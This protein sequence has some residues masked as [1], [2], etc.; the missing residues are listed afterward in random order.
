ML[1]SIGALIVFLASTAALVVIQ[2]AGYA[3]ALRARQSQENRNT[4]QDVGRSFT[5]V[6][7]TLLLTVPLLLASA[8]YGVLLH[9]F[10]NWK[11]YLIGSTVAL[12]AQLVSLEGPALIQYS[13]MVVTKFFFPVYNDVILP[14]LNVLRVLWNIAAC[15]VSSWF[16]VQTELY[17]GWISTIAQ[18]SIADFPL[19]VEIVANLLLEFAEEVIR[20]VE[21]GADAD[22]DSYPA[23][24]Q[25]ANFTL[26]V[27]NVTHCACSDIDLLAVLVTEIV[28]NSKAHGA[29]F[30]W[31]NVWLST[32]RTVVFFFV[33]ILIRNVDF[34]TCSDVADPH[35]RLLCQLKRG[36]KLDRIAA[37]LC[38]TTRD[39]TG[40]IDESLQTTVDLFW[41]P[42]LV[43]P[44]LTIDISSRN[45]EDVGLGNGQSNRVIDLSD[46]LGKLLGITIKVPPHQ[47]LYS[48]PICTMIY[49]TNMTVDL[50]LHVDMIFYDSLQSSYALHVPVAP[51]IQDTCR[52]LTRGLELFTDAILDT[53]DS[54]VSVGNPLVGT[55]NLLQM[56]TNVWRAGVR[57]VTSLIRLICD[58]LAFYV[59]LAQVYLFDQRLPG[60]A[61]V[62]TF[63]K[64]TGNYSDTD[65]E[66]L[67][68]INQ[69]LLDFQE[70]SSNLTNTISG[71]LADAFGFTFL[72]LNDLLAALFDGILYARSNDLSGFFESEIY[73]HLARAATHRKQAEVS[74]ANV[75][76]EFTLGPEIN[77]NVPMCSLVDP[78]TITSTSNIRTSVSSPTI[79]PL[80]CA[81]TIAQNVF[82]LF[83]TFLENTVLI[84]L[85][86]INQI[87]FSSSGQINSWFKVVLRSG[88]FLEELRLSARGLSSGIACSLSSPL[89]FG[90]ILTQ[91]TVSLF[92]CGGEENGNTLGEI[93]FD[94][95]FVALR[96][97]LESP[98]RAILVP[99]KL[100]LGLQCDFVG[101][102]LGFS[103]AE[104]AQVSP[105][106]K[107]SLNEALLEVYRITIGAWVDLYGFLL[108]IVR[109]VVLEVTP[110]P[111]G[112]GLLVV[113]TDIFGSG[114]S[115]PSLISTDWPTVTEILDPIVEFMG[116]VTEFTVDL[117]DRKRAPS[118][119][120]WN[121]WWSGLTTLILTVLSPVIEYS[122]AL[123]L[124]FADLTLAVNPL[125]PSSLV[126]FLDAFGSCFIATPF[127]GQEIVDYF[128]DD[129]VAGLGLDNIVSSLTNLSVDLNDFIDAF[130]FLRIAV[131]VGY[132]QINTVMVG[133]QSLFGIGSTFNPWTG[134]ALTLIPTSVGP[135]S[136]NPGLPIYRRKRDHWDPEHLPSFQDYQYHRYPWE[137]RLEDVFGDESDHNETLVSPNRT[138][139]LN[140]YRN[141]LL[142][143]V[144]FVSLRDLNWT[145]I[146]SG[147]NFQN[148]TQARAAQVCLGEHLLQ[149]QA[150]NLT[151]Q[152]SPEAVRQILRALTQNHTWDCVLDVATVTTIDQ[153]VYALFY[154][155]QWPSSYQMM[156]P[157]TL[158]NSWALLQT[159]VQQIGQ[160]LQYIFT[161]QYMLPSEHTG[162][163]L[164]FVHGIRVSWR[165]TLFYLSDSAALYMHEKTPEDIVAFVLHAR[166]HVH[167]LKRDVSQAWSKRHDRRALEQ[168]RYEALVLEREEQRSQRAAAMTAHPA[169]EEIRT[170]GDFIREKVLVPVFATNSETAEYQD[171]SEKR[172][173]P[174]QTDSFVGAYDEVPM[175]VLR[176]HPLHR[177]LQMSDLI[178]ERLLGSRRKR[179][180]ERTAT[181]NKSLRTVNR[182]FTGVYDVQHHQDL[183]D[184]DL[185]DEHQQREALFQAL[186]QR[187]PSWMPRFD[188]DR[189]DREQYDDRLR[190]YAEAHM[191]RAQHPPHEH[192]G[193]LHK[194]CLH[195]ADQGLVKR[196]SSCLNQTELDRP[197]LGLETIFG[198][199]LQVRCLLLTR[200]IVNI[201]DI[202]CDCVDR[203]ADG[204]TVEAS[205]AANKTENGTVIVDPEAGSR[206]R[207]LSSTF[208]RYLRF[209]YD[210]EPQTNNTAP[211]PNP[212]P[213]VTTRRIGVN[214]LDDAVEW[215]WMP[216]QWLFGTE[217]SAY[218]VGLE[219]FR[220]FTETDTDNPNGLVYYLNWF[221]L[222]DCAAQRSCE[223]SRDGL[224]LFW[225][226]LVVILGFLVLITFTTLF[227]LPFAS[228]CNLYVLVVILILGLTVG[229][230]WSPLC[231]SR[232]VVPLCLAD[233]LYCGL[234]VFGT[235]CINYDH[236]LPGITENRCPTTFNSSVT[237]RDFIQWT[238]APYNFNNGIRTVF[239]LFELYNVPVAPFLLTT[240]LPL[241]SWIRQLP[242]VAQDMTWEFPPGEPTDDYTSAFL[243][244]LLQVVP[245][246]A[247]AALGTVLFFSLLS[248]FVTLFLLAF[249]ILE[250]FAGFLGD[251]VVRVTGGGYVSDTRYSY[252]T[253]RE[254]RMLTPLSPE[255]K[256]RE[257]ADLEQEL[258]PSVESQAEQANVEL[259]FLQQQQKLGTSLQ[260][261]GAHRATLRQRT[262]Y[263]RRAQRQQTATQTKHILLD[264]DRSDEPSFAESLRQAVR[265]VSEVLLPVTAYRSTKR[266][267][268]HASRR[269]V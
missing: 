101:A 145:A 131:L 37:H 125:T 140:S 117:F 141:N 218:Q 187:P 68:P 242:R 208:A 232:G 91:S 189:H 152:E 166:E 135:F 18:C 89:E 16:Y 183:S 85:D 203:V 78:R 75:F 168:D 160:V 221:F 61:N 254:Q 165:T 41:D 26:V 24:A 69:D 112:F 257:L 263:S 88:L 132:S 192:A 28:T 63:L 67:N 29:L 142:P 223:N 210:L 197:E 87:V 122:E 226:Y 247:F 259:L 163:L 260:P 65:T 100:Y 258:R 2:V 62:N 167:H 169:H 49:A 246:L 134:A 238:E 182:H 40:L 47:D 5:G 39:V 227:G 198:V 206:W 51:L 128:L 21:L 217:K 240:N 252:R 17:Y 104:C 7:R 31:I 12:G 194:R 129:L 153:L 115:K 188:P 11:L 161:D 139:I 162:A 19:I 212:D 251:A 114:E 43:R 185:Y 123:F 179:Y 27:E 99:V 116:S 144:F 200:P 109:C 184:L 97:V 77:I 82:A 126:D 138:E 264:D 93:V 151:D 245:L 4:V 130:N 66:Y 164:T 148:I 33:D 181:P 23:S 241:F 175:P 211:D 261:A 244:S 207:T 81:A 267:T 36:P 72:Y 34:F 255:E 56:S 230:F 176:V 9:I 137:T 234:N 127:P 146:F 214:W 228:L 30:H 50:L 106:L 243:L 220:F 108:D 103:T 216:V 249:Q 159:V 96:T 231:L 229:Y 32:G 38:Q 42:D 150:F 177:M 15:W 147:D 186:R 136:F 213:P 64:S 124:C 173:E 156:D 86:L 235:D 193:E 266:R 250:L 149:A 262:A 119:A 199:D 70:N 196:V 55:S 76:R 102:V 79:E 8:F 73:L 171:F 154:Q 121:L 202:I 60:L 74:L 170:M 57:V 95:S 92:Q 120:D 46:R 268:T 256:Q 239:F 90:A 48:T 191:V 54:V 237:E 10:T 107:F 233:D 248:L 195:L 6:L 265:L 14:I 3:A 20:F 201:I 111:P 205:C 236:F 157:A 180:Y 25:L 133:A 13:D 94:A 209:E 215:L 80:C 118:I 222:P 269:H 22:F 172:E 44:G 190:L 98:I 35:S 225:G 224:G 143:P 204:F 58:V 253:S 83:N 155:P 113:S 45:D 219:V 174:Y 178:R 53:I 158:R 110:K 71:S 52:N 105:S 1:T 59:R 84:S